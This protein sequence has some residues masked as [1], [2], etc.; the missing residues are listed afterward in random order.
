ME[1]PKKE[2]EEGW[3]RAREAARERVLQEFEKGQLGLAST[4]VIS[5]SSSN[6]ESS[7]GMLCLH[8]VR[9]PTSSSFHNTVLCAEYRG[10]AR[11]TNRMFNLDTSAVERLTRE[12]EEAA[13]RQIERQQAEALKSKCPNFWLP[14]LPP[15][16]TFSGPPMSP[17]DVKLQTTC[18]GGN[19]AH[20]S[21]YVVHA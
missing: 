3:E 2:A 6:A 11:G 16:Y 1:A 8:I 21:A 4:S 9:F 10:L 18:R 20:P 7:V 14:S 17:S 13:L 12:A 15:T 19:P 5:T